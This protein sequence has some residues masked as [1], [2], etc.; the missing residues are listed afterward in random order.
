LPTIKEERRYPNEVNLGLFDKPG[1]Q[2]GS[3]LGSSGF[4]AGRIP[5]LHGGHESKR[6]PKQTSEKTRILRHYNLE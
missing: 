5:N 3:S 1:I 6:I 4:E 2:Q